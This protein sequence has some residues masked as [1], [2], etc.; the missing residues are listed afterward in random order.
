MTDRRVLLVSP[1]FHGYWRALRAAFTSLGYEVR[2]HC[3]DAPVS[4]AAA[5]GNKLLHELPG[6]AGVDRIRK[7]LTERAIRLLRDWRPSRVL[8]VK[9]DLLTDDWWQELSGVGTPTVTWLY[10]ELRRTGWTIQQLRGAGA[11]ATYSPHD[12]ASLRAAGLSAAY[13]PLGFDSLQPFTVETVD[14]V[15]LIGARYPNRERFL[16]QLQRR[17]VPVVAYGRAWSRN[18]WDIARTRQLRGAGVP[19]NRDLVREDAYGV[20]AGSIA[21]LNIHGDQD[22]FTMRTF[23]AA[24]V[25]GVQLVDRADVVEHYDP[26]AEVLVFSSDEEAAGHAIRVRRDRTWARG[27]RDAA[28]RRTLAQHTLV[29]RARALEALW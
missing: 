25:G 16:R 19:S 5:V 14:A 1:A 12:A 8:V 24:G 9:G 20:M 7:S 13:V 15:T 10:D 17:G 27:L 2:G 4:P 28:R 11:V 29:H 6:H 22:G 23:E 18:P 3:Y 26:G 21:T